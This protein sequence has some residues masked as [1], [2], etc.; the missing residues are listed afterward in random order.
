MRKRWQQ[1]ID[2]EYDKSLN[3]IL[4]G[5]ISKSKLRIENFKISK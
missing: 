3:D 5:G 1:V 4:L 2:Q